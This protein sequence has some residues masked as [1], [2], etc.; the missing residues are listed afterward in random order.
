MTLFKTQKITISKIVPELV[1]V[2]KCGYTE[3][4]SGEDEMAEGLDVEPVCPK[5]GKLMDSV[6]LSP[7]NKPTITIEKTNPK[8]SDVS[9]G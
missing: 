9:G 4:I 3:T 1:L 5:C 8:D 7:Q 2:C 6:P